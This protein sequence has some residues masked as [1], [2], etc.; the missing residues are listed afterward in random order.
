MRKPAGRAPRSDGDGVAAA[1]GEDDG[2]GEG[3]AD[4]GGTR[5]A[6][7]AA[8]V[9]PADADADAPGPPSARSSLPPGSP[10]AAAT[11]A[12]VTVATARGVPT[13]TPFRFHPRPDRA[14]ASPARAPRRGPHATPG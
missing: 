2:G 7:S 12:A 10:V 6:G 4:V 14:Y 3:A 1:D 9:P 8:P 13:S 11:T 5:G